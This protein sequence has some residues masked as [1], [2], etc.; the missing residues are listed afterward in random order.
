MECAIWPPDCW[1]DKRAC[2][3]GIAVRSVRILLVGALIFL[4]AGLVLADSVPTDPS[5]GAG[6]G[7]LSTEIFFPAFTFNLELCGRLT[8]PPECTSPPGPFTNPQAVFAGDND[9]G[10]PWD[11]LTLTLNFPALASE[12]ILSCFGGTLFSSSD[13][14][15]NLPAESN[16]V[17]FKLFGV[18]PGMGTGIGCFDPKDND[19]N[20]PNGDFQANLNCIL[21][22][23][24]LSDNFSDECL[25][26]GDDD[27]ED[28]APTAPSH[29]VIA[30]GFNNPGT[31]TRNPW[32]PGSIP[33][34]GSGAA[35]VPE[36]GTMAL[37]LT[38]MGALVARS[39]HRKRHISRS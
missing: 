3:G 14:P 36:P 5:A 22:T 19:P 11:S 28:C 2:S 20:D 15:K 4:C 26:N 33:T 16:S 9:S 39:S 7:G 13:C 18:G 27:E 1:Q 6:G 34:G 25:E 35:N 30:V 17:T 32:P 37:V 8:S 10:V 23:P 21:N 31:T 29:F 38:G 24:N 12:Q